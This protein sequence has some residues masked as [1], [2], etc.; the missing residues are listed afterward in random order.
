[1][2]RGH[3]CCVRLLEL[4]RLASIGFQLRPELLILYVCVS[5]LQLIH[6]RQSML[7]ITHGM[8]TASEVNLS[9][10]LVANLN[11]RISIFRI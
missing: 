9:L 6:R 8:P 10:R 3:A 4:L 2:T 7:V 11:H 5:K 1:M